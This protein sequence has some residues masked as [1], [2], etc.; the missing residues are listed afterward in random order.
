M[1]Q[2]KIIFVLTISLVSILSTS[3]SALDINR[4]VLSNGLNVLH[5]KRHNLPIVMLTLLIKASPLNEP[6]DKA[7]LASLTAGLLTE[8]TKNR[9]ASMISEE[10]EFIGAS[11]SASTGSDYTTISL[12]VLKKDI[13]KGFELLSDV[14]LNPTFPEEEIQREK[15]LIEGSLRQNEEMP[16][17]IAEK[18]F[19]KELYG[20]H[21]YGRLIQGSPETLKNIQRT[22]I[23]KFYLDYF[24]PNNAILSVAGDLTDEELDS[25]VK[26]FLGEWKNADV[27]L[28]KHALPKPPAKKM[29]KIDKDLTQANII[30]GGL[31]VKR[32]NPDYYILSVMNYILG[33]GGFSSRLMQSVRD[34]MGLAY[35]IHSS[36]TPGKDSG[37]FQVVVQTK[38]ESANEVISEILKEIKRIREENVTPAELEDAKAFLIGSFAGKIDTMRKISDFLAVVEFY[39]LGMDYIEKYPLYISSVTQEDILRAAKKYLDIE[40]LIIV[41]VADE[42]KAKI[43]P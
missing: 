36:F 15:E 1:K 2:A 8:G 17:F 14:L 39:G 38:N 22:D 32:D 31:G 21:S 28:H 7:G 6:S 40:N 18:A 9:T 33:G 4:R 5:V 23:V 30:V 12:S 25:L 10:I 41:V 24:V 3:T 43:M 16:S 37:A 34:E 13:E 20:E 27:P 42:A 19:K 35:D 11:L 29:L 26:R